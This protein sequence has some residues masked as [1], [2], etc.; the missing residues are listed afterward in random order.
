MKRQNII[1][2]LKSY[3]S[4][5]K[6]SKNPVLSSALTHNKRIRFNLLTPNEYKI[7]PMKIK[8]A[9]KQYLIDNINSLRKNYFNYNKGI[10]YSLEEINEMS[11]KNKQFIQRYNNMISKSGIVN[12]NAFSHIRAQYEKQDY[13]LPNLEDGNNLFKSNLL[14]SSN[15]TDLKKYINLGYGTNKSNKKTISFLERINENINNDTNDENQLYNI[16][17]FT[18]INANLNHRYKRDLSTLYALNKMSKEKL[19][20]ILTYKREI[21]KLERTIDSILDIDYFFSSDNKEYLDTLRFFNSRNTSANFST[22]LGNNNSTLFDKNN[23]GNKSNILS[24]RN[25]SKITF[26]ENESKSSN[27]KNK[28]LKFNLDT[29]TANT[30]IVNNS[31]ENKSLTQMIRKP[32]KKKKIVKKN[33]NRDNYKQTLET[34]YNKITTSD[35]STHN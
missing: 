1:D 15:D 12:K 5:D 34:L 14:L 10:H 21:K 28:K 32:K 24:L 18:N 17:Y 27:T 23:F 3:I 7:I 25:I 31:I 30:F 13:I 11:K 19:K 20:E 22:S 35:D 9:K 6:M 2:K 16:N 29:N 8:N 4:I 33:I 26:D